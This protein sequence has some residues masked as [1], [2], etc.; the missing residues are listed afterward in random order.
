M[1]KEPE[2]IK[3]TVKA[4]PE[5]GFCRCGMKFTREGKDVEVT[6]AQLEI[7]KNEKLLVVSEPK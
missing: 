2:K 5:K 3:V 1:A 4:V 6:P 7:L